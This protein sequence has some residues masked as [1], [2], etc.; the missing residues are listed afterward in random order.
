MEPGYFLGVVELEPELFAVIGLVSP[1][2]HTRQEII[3]V[4]TMR[5]AGMTL[6][7]MIMM[8]T[9]NVWI[10]AQ[11]SVQQTCHRFVSIT[12]SSAVKHD[13]SIVQSRL[14]SAANAAANQ[15]IHTGILQ[16]RNQSAV[17]AVVR[18]Q[19][20][21]VVQHL[22]FSNQSYFQNVFKKQYGVTP[23]QYRKTSGKPWPPAGIFSRYKFSPFSAMTPEYQIAESFKTRFWVE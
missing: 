15:R 8:V 11:R 3:P 14:R 10:K 12:R 21:G 19:Q 22:C 18:V 9:M 2:A 23:L 13:P 1:F 6:S 16:E 20:P 17:A 5:T 4:T 7:V